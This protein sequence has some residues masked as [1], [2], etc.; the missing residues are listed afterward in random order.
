MKKH[1]IDIQNYERKKRRAATGCFYHRHYNQIIVSREELYFQLEKADLNENLIACLAFGHDHPQYDYW[2][3][4]ASINFWFIG[5][6]SYPRRRKHQGQEYHKG[7]KLKYGARRSKKMPFNGTGTFEYSAAKPS[8][9]YYKKVIFDSFLENEDEANTWLEHLYSIY[10]EK[11]NIK[12][13]QLFLKYTAVRNGCI[14]MLASTREFYFA[15]EYKNII[16][17]IANNKVFMLEF[18]SKYGDM[19]ILPNEYENIFKNG[20]YGDLY[21]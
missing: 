11:P 21:R 5:S 14:R 10:R 6:L 20:Y 16:D 19:P 15:E 9:E 7:K 3:L 13:D 2:L 18:R 4:M 8:R 12:A 17:Y 1:L